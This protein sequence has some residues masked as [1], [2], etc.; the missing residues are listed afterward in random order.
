MRQGGADHARYGSHRLDD[1]RAVAVPLAEKRVREEAHRLGE[2]ECNSVAEVF[3]TAVVDADGNVVDHVFL[4][5][6]AAR[7]GGESHK[8]YPE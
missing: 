4:P 6:C 3:G 7:Q 2:A 5:R 1:D 8:V